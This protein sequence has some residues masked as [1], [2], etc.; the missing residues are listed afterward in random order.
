MTNEK[1]VV[2]Y[3]PN[4]ADSW[5]SL[6]HNSCQIL[7]DL[8]R[9]TVSLQNASSHLYQGKN[10]DQH[11]PAAANKTIVISIHLSFNIQLIPAELGPFLFRKRRTMP[12]Q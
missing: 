4:D 12:L 11:F 3:S 5:A 8:R 6:T 1:A 10:I 7:F 2:R 9:V